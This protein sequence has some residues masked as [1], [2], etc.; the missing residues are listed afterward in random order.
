MNA[1][2][3]SSRYEDYC[4]LVHSETRGKAKAAACWDI[5]CEF[6]EVNARRLPGQDDKPFTYENAKEAGFRYT[7]EDG[8]YDHDQCESYLRPDEFTNYCTCDVCRNKVQ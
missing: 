1:W 7:D 3:V 6:T 4:V 2:V 5:E 8:V